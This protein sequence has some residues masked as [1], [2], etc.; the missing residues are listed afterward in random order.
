[1]PHVDL[2]PEISHPDGW[3]AAVLRTAWNEKPLV[4]QVPGSRYLP[5]HELWVVPL[6]WASYLQV[7]GVFPQATF[8]D[9]YQAW[10]HETYRTK[11]APARALRDLTSLDLYTYD[12]R[13]R[14]YQNAT[15]AWGQLVGSG[16]NGNEMGLGKTVETLWILRALPRSLPAL[17]ACPN[18]VKEHWEK[19]TGEWFPEATPYVLDG[20]A[21]K[22]LKTINEARKDPSALVIIN[23]ESARLFSRLAP[24]GSVKLVRCRE[25]DPRYG[26]EG[27]TSSRCH[28]HP[29]PLNGFG[30]RSVVVDEIHR[31]ASPTSQQT[32]ALWALGHD[33]SVVYRWGTTGTML[34]NDPV[35]LWSQLHFI[36]P[37]EHPTKSQFVERYALMSWNAHGGMS[38]IGLR[39]DTRDEFFAFFDW[40]YRRMLKAVVATQLPPKVYGVRYVDLGRAQR[41]MYT[42]LLQDSTTADAAGETIV[43]TDV[44]TNRT[45]RAQL[46]VASLA[47]MEKPDE[48]DPRTWK[49]ALCEPSPVLDE[50]ERVVEELGDEQFVVAAVSKQLIDLMARRLDAR[51]V[52][53]GLITGDVTPKLRAE[54]QQALRD[55]KIRALLFTVQA[56][57]TGVDLSAA[58]N[59]IFVQRPDSMIDYLQAEDRVHRIGSEV[60][61]MVNV[62]H[63]VARDTVEADKSDNILEKL[64]RLEEINRDLARLQ[65]AQGQQNYL[66]ALEAEKN[67]IVESW[68]TDA[69]T[70]QEE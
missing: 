27:L 51:G 68:T 15:V 47:V 49:M 32:R 18:S 57:G 60:H 69:P 44:L 10:V 61:D 45:R 25:C 67:D 35:D 48:D 31:L 5:R 12:E 66:L 55:G 3:P 14:A 63:V 59:I 4:K 29:K 42:E 16:I 1:M 6:T 8:S 21:P 20:P 40:R 36:T 17:V 30:F 28:V 38:V 9:A 24:Y 39:P 13:L 34:R 41:K 54:A 23:L 65:A 22:R 70:R 50:A 58:R 19:R 7:R 46:S 64:R 37:D 62:I 11:V 53:Y 52:R 2:D 56:G 43:T 26:E 33:P